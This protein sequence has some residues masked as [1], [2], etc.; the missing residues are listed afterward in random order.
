V[1]RLK[2][3]DEQNA[4]YELGEIMGKVPDEHSSI[5]MANE[6]V[7]RRYS[8]VSYEQS[9][10]GYYGLDCEWRVPRLAVHKT[11]AVVTKNC[12]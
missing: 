12:Q 11:S 9:K 7:R 6:Y 2:R 3:L 1:L 5:A 4:V 10:L 8:G